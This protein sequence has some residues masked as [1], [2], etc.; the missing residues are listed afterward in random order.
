M[1]INHIYELKDYK[2]KKD[3]FLKLKMQRI[4]QS[5]SKQNVTS[6]ILTKKFHTCFEDF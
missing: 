1:S 2:K 6:D 5:R 3:G 4:L